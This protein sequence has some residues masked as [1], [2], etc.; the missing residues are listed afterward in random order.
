MKLEVFRISSAED[1][2]SGVLFIVDDTA[3]SPHNEGF[4][5]KRS[6]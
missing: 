1:S 5:C 3:D 6:L 2:T 4:R